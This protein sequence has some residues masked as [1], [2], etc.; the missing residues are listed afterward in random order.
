MFSSKQIRS[1]PAKWNTIQEKSPERVLNHVIDF[2]E[3]IFKLISDDLGI[4][5]QSVPSNETEIR[6]DVL[7]ILTFT[8]GLN[9]VFSS[10]AGRNHQNAFF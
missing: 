5:Q 1:D 4:V 9:K 8:V 3:G 6:K 10:K 7:E 2:I